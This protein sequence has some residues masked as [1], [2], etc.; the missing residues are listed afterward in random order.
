MTETIAVALITAVSGIAGVAVGALFAFITAKS[1]RRNEYEKL[2]FEKRLQAYQEFST[3]FG[4]YLKATESAELY[5]NLLVSTQK[6]YL[7]ASKETCH[8]VSIISYLLK[9][10]SPQKPV[11]QKFMDYNRKLMDSFRMDLSSYKGK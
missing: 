11:T 4:E 1:T 9:D 7:V 8:Y 6:V 10:A 5:A 3:D 2:L